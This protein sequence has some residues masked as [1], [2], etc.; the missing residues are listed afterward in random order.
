MPNV[1]EVSAI[2][3]VAVDG[4][5]R[6]A[7]GLMEKIA[8]DLPEVFGGSATDTARALHVTHMDAVGIS[9]LG[10]SFQSNLERFGLPRTATPDDLYATAEKQGFVSRHVSSELGANYYANDYELS[11]GDGNVLRQ[12]M[13]AGRSQSY[14]ATSFLTKGTGEITHHIGRALGQNSESWELKSAAPL[15]KQ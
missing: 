5:E 14:Q 12:T 3:A 6:L 1:Q 2:A 4:A 11:L 9:R 7:P 10:H 8:A 13:S 15:E